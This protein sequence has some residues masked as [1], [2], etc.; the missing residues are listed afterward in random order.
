M[1]YESLCYRH[2]QSILD[3]NI[4][5]SGDVKIIIKRIAI[6]FPILFALASCSKAPE[7]TLKGLDDQ[8]HTLSEYIDQGKW[9][10]VNVWSTGCP[11]CRMEMPE[12]QDFYDTHKDK[13]ATVLGIAVD[14][15]GFGYPDLHTVKAYTLDYFIDFPSLLADADQ[16][17]ELIGAQ[18]KMIP[19]TFFYNP[20]GKMVGR[21]EGTIT[22]REIEKVINAPPKNSKLFGS[23]SRGARN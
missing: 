6:L 3:P 18:V 1:V 17:S 19:I 23:G 21:W 15:P 20:N 14:F 13:D 2:D 12:L 9:T 11:Y 10:I 4:F 5:R 8:E 7:A 16:A 22:K